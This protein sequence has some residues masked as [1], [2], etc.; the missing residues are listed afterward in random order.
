MFMQPFKMKSCSPSSTASCQLYSRK[1]CRLRCTSASTLSS[2]GTVGQLD[3]INGTLH[4]W[5]GRQVRCRCNLVHLVLT[6]YLWQRGAG[7]QAAQRSF[8][9]G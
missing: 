9:Q 3:N 5:L 6:K 4:A 2:H 7:Q 1:T 8:H